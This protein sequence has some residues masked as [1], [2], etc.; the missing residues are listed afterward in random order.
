[1]NNHDF[2][3]LLDDTLKGCA[4]VL[5]AKS[6][7]YARHDDRLHNFKVIAAMR[8]VTPEDALI[9]LASKQWVSILDMVA[10]LDNDRLASMA[11]WNEK[12]GDVINYL[13]LLRALAAERSGRKM[14]HNFEDV[15][16]S[17]PTQNACDDKPE[18][19]FA[20]RYGESVANY[21][22]RLYRANTELQK[23]AEKSNRKKKGRRS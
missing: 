16:L 12:I 6:T 17:S 13:V 1:M 7:E 21:V 4:A 8:T 18:K 14:P 10:D 2:S 3:L 20:I 5:G 22:E 9:G 23:F 11:Q 15:T 19:A